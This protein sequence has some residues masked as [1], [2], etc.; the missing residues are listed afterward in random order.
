MIHKR[1]SLEQIKLILSDFDG[2]LTFPSHR[3]ESELHRKLFDIFEFAENH[4]KELVIISGRPL[5]WGHFFLSHFPVNKVILEGGGI[6][7]FRNEEKSYTSR[8]R[9]DHIHEE[10]LISEEE[11]LHL[12]TVEKELLEHFPQIRLSFDSWG[13]KT[14]RAIDLNILTTSLQEKIEQFLLKKNVNYSTSSIHL[15]FWVGHFSKY[16]AYERLQKKHYPEIKKEECLYFGDALNDQSMFAQMPYS[17]GVSNISK[18][19]PKMQH[20]P[21][22]ILKGEQNVG[23]LG[24]HQFLL[25]L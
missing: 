11:L 14:D 5:S 19:L 13:R 4:H 25:S 10:C 17:V 7:L 12:E 22:F 20:P 9:S 6:Y 1:P 8:R 18:D 24:V 2:T 23:P 16:L 3:L 21:K 15:N